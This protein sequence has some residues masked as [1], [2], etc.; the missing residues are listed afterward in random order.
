M[1]ARGFLVGRLNVLSGT[2]CL[3]LGQFFGPA[4]DSMD[5]HRRWNG[6]VGVLARLGCVVSK[7]ANDLGA[8]HG[9]P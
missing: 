2:I 3:G 5:M 9:V 6:R 4:L 7:R 8:A 1:A